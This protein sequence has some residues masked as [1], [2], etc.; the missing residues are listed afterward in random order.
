MKKLLISLSVLFALVGCQTQTGKNMVDITMQQ[1]VS[2]EYDLF[3]YEITE[4]FGDE[5]NG[6]GLDNDGGIVLSKEYDNVDFAEGDV[7][8][9]AFEKGI[10]DA[11]VDIQ[12]IN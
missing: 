10:E 3:T 9:V 11:I 12:K 7:I 1:T 4:V 8:V 5:I 2:E 6:L